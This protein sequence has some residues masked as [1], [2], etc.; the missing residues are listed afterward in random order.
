MI[1]YSVIGDI[2]VDERYLIELDIT[3]N[4]ILGLG[5]SK[6]AVVL[7]DIFHK[8]KPSPLEVQFVLKWFKKLVAHYGEVIVILGNHDLYGGL[9]TTK[10]LRYLGVTVI[11]SLEWISTTPYGS[12]LFGHYF[13][14]ESIDNYTGATRSFKTFQQGYK[15]VFLGHQHRFQ[16][17]T[18]TIYHIGSIRYVGFGEYSKPL[19][20]AP[21]RI[22]QISDKGDLKFIDLKMPY[23]LVQFKDLAGLLNHYKNRPNSNVISDKV[24]IV[25]EDFNT[26]KNDINKLAQ[27]PWIFEEEIKL[28]LDFKN[29]HLIKNFNTSINGCQLSTAEVVQ[30]WLENI[31]DAEVKEILEKESKILCD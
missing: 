22:A 28:K 3:F 10:I 19:P 27:L 7:G 25:Y 31:Q 15:Y 30:K 23:P 1:D 11:E 29:L 16:E 2:H 18:P 4:E 8:H 14:A 12:L 26:Y 21:K 24:R 17:F 9:Q 6:K 13:L 5:K 20:L